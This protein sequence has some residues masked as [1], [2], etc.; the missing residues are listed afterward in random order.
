MKIHSVSGE[1]TK[2]SAIEHVLKGFPP[3]EDVKASRDPGRSGYL[4]KPGQPVFGECFPHP[5]VILLCFPD[6][7]VGTV[8]FESDFG[9]WPPDGVFWVADIL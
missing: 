4:L 8:C 6:L 3:A 1:E 9:S 7:V 5:R 2:H